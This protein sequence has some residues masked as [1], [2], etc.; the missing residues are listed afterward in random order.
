MFKVT[1]GFIAGVS[2]SVLHYDY[3]LSPNELA[4]IILKHG[5]SFVNEVK[6]NSDGQSPV[7]DSLFGHNGLFHRPN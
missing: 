3:G 4:D 2:L 7:T 5:K 1:F 6:E